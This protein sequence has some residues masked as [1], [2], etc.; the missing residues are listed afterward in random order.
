VVLHA[1]VP[2]PQKWILPKIKDGRIDI[3]RLDMHARQV[4]PGKVEEFFTYSD[5]ILRNV[6]MTILHIFVMVTEPY[7]YL[8]FC[9]MD[10]WGC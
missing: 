6:N 8:R 2:K 1:I 9:I 5:L 3:A 10:D 7:T 4:R